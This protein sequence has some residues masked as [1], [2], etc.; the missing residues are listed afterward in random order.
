MIRAVR[1]NPCGMAALEGTGPRACC[2]V[3]ADIAIN[4]EG[5]LEAGGNK[6]IEPVHGFLGGPCQTAEHEGP[7]NGIV[8]GP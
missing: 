6:V 5:L 7:E 3:T 2:A 1:A 4:A 8:K